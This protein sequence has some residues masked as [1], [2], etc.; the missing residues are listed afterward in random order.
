LADL[1]ECIPLLESAQKGELPSAAL[2]AKLE[3][4]KKR[5]QAEAGRLDELITVPGVKHRYFM[6]AV[7]TQLVPLAQGGE[8][9]S[10]LPQL[11]DWQKRLAESKPSVR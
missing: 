7:P 9:A 11:R 10:L 6:S 4:M 5:D 1:R 3:E 8:A 2:V